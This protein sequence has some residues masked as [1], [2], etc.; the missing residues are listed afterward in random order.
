MG[1]SS[2][3]AMFICLLQ[4]QVS[5]GLEK[6]GPAQTV[7]GFSLHPLDLC[8]IENTTF[9]A[10]EELVVKLYY[11][12]SFVWV[13]AGEAV[14]KVEDLVDQ[15]RISV[16]GKTYSFFDNFFKVRDRYIC[17][18]DKNTL[19]PIQSIRDVQEGKYT[20]Y[21]HLVFHPK[22]HK[23]TSNRSRKKKP[24]VKTTYEVEDCMHDLVSLIYYVRNVNFDTIPDNSI[25]PVHVFID[26]QTFNL[27]LAYLRK[28]EKKVKGLGKQN[29]LLFTPEVIDG[30]VF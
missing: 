16:T 7:D 15:Y 8:G 19:R 21:D 12:L 28:E 18:L 26:K 17:Y 14:F 22:E 13:A 20:L 10:E 11:K 30:Y 29:T 5:P 2:Y 3:I 25:L 27:E 23:V 1:L 6:H 9:I 4:V 24:F